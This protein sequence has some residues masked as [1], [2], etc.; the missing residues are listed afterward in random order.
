MKTLGRKNV[1]LQRG[2]PTMESNLSPLMMAMR[3]SILFA[4]LEI[5]LGS[6]ESMNIWI[7]PCKPDCG[8]HGIL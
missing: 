5:D 2:T 4:E 8:G 1:K 6:R 3:R 7:Q